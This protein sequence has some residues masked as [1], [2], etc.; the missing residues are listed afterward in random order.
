MV[1]CIRS[2]GSMIHKV[3]VSISFKY[4]HTRLDRFEKKYKT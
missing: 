4:I 1:Q 3:Y 2:L